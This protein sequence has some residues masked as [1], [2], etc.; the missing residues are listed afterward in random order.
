MKETTLQ[1]LGLG[2]GDGDVGNDNLFYSRRIGTPPQGYPDLKD[3]WNADVPKSVNH[4]WSS[5]AYRKNKN[6]LSLGFVEAVT[7]EDE[8]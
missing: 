5:K 2:I 6:G 7:A 8:S 3:G 4:T 1:I